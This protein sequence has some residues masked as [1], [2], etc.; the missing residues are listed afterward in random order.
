M[1]QKNLDMGYNTMKIKK[2]TLNYFSLNSFPGVF[3]V[4]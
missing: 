1:G 4:A 3:P 2:A